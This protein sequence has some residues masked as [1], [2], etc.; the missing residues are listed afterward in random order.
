MKLSTKGRYGVRL[1][2]DIAEH[3]GEGPVFLKDIAMR[4]DISEKYLWHLTAVLKTAGLI[5]SIRGAHGGYILARK[6]AD[7]TLK[8]IV[9]PLE[10]SMCLVACV[11]NPSVCKRAGTCATREIWTDTSKKISEVLTSCTLDAMVEKQKRKSGVVT[12]SI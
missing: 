3:S 7:I 12:Y 8:D 4:Q 11:D 5:N 2:V 6:A 1:M 10:G 9:V